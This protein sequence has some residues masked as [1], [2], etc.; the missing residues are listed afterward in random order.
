MSNNLDEVQPAKRKESV[1]KIKN[2]LS[3]YILLIGTTLLSSPSR[4]M[5]DSEGIDKNFSVHTPR[6][7]LFSYVKSQGLQDGHGEFNRLAEQAPRIKGYPAFVVQEDPSRSKWIRGQ[8]QCKSEPEATELAQDIEKILNKGVHV[9][10]PGTVTKGQDF[11]LHAA[12]RH[13]WK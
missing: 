7:Q 2:T 10:P 13:T 11:P 12:I 6:V 8:L 9:V 5:D 3:I 1:M 4:A